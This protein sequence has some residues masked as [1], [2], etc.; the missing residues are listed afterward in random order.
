MIP[1]D[2]RTRYDTE[3]KPFVEPITQVVMVGRNEDGIY[4]SN[5]FLYVE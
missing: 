2:E 4:S 1:A 5:V 3:V